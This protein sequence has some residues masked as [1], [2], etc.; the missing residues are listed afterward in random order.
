MLDLRAEEKRLNGFHFFFHCGYPPNQLW[1][2]HH[3][4]DAKSGPDD[5][6]C[7][8]SPVSACHKTFQRIIEI[9][10]LVDKPLDDSPEAK[11]GNQKPQYE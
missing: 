11:G 10:Q 3:N 5:P 8:Y 6:P 7:I 2:K 4:E 1:Q 9:R